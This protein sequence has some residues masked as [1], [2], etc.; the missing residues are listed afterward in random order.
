MPT[1]TVEHSV[2]PDRGTGPTLMIAWH[3]GDHEPPDLDAV[4]RMDAQ[5]STTPEPP[6]FTLTDVAG[7]LGGNPAVV[8]VVQDQLVGAGVSRADDDRAWVL[9][10]ALPPDLVEVARLMTRRRPSRDAAPAVAELD[11]RGVGRGGSS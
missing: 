7:Y 3:G 11:E 6:I 9:R 8:T 5:S 1:V 10:P 2:G 4:V